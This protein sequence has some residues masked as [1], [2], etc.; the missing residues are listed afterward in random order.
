MAVRRTSC[1][2]VIALSLDLLSPV[3]GCKFGRRKRES[4]SGD[5]KS[6]NMNN[7]IHDS[8]IHIK[9]DGSLGQR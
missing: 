1:L 8:V 5:E 2:L 9:A 3:D 7:K 6:V 4:T